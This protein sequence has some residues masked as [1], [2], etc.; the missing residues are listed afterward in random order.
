MSRK[1]LTIA[2]EKASKISGSVLAKATKKPLRF[3]VVT[4]YPD[5][6]DFSLPIMPSSVPLCHPYPGH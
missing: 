3:A 2:M 4:A 1:P 6:E 5:S